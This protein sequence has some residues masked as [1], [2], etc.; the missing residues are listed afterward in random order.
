MVS[1]GE[2]ET[3]NYV[4][5]ENHYWK[6]EC[7][8]II[9]SDHVILSAAHCFR[10]GHKSIR[11]GD[12][13]LE[14]QSDN[15]FAAT[16]TVN[17]IFKH[18]KYFTDT[19]EYDLAVVLTIEKIAFNNRTKP[20]CLPQSPSDKSYTGFTAYIAGWGQV[21]EWPV[22]TRTNVSLRKESYKVRMA[23]SRQF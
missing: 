13:Y 9:V 12:E 7:G 14:D 16:Y 15:N 19:I 1:I 10:N 6:H 3:V 2:L 20:I 17:T 22:H 5:N 18:P 8:G 11:T 21:D 4:G 23:R